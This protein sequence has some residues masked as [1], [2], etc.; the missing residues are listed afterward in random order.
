[1]KKTFTALIL[2]VIILAICTSSIA[3][4][5]IPN[6]KEK[7]LTEEIIFIQ[8]FLSE[9]LSV[10]NE[11]REIKWISKSDSID[12]YSL[13]LKEAGIEHEVSVS[14]GKDYYN[15]QNDLRE[16]VF[17]INSFD[18]V[19]ADP[20]YLYNYIDIIVSFLYFVAPDISDEEFNEVL[21]DATE[22]YGEYVINHNYDDF[23]YFSGSSGHSISVDYVKINE[24]IGQI[25]I[26]IDIGNSFM[27]SLFS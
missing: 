5:V 24:V 7:T 9:A 1:M 21:I 17:L 22:Y 25:R 19:N 13:L 20:I 3:E 10:L 8:E 27:S 23:Y 16:V 4:S 26:V 6:S 11:D 15:D 14:F 2:F 12:M 18:N